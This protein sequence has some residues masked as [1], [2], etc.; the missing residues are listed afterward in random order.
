MKIG[1]DVRCFA[2]KRH[3][4]VEEYTRNLLVKLVESSPEHSFVLFFNAFS[5]DI[6]NFSWITKYPNV[7][8]CRKRIPNK[9]L[10]VCLW[11][12]RRPYLDALIGGVDVFFAP[13]LG[14]L[15]VSPKCRFVVTVHDLSY[16]VYSQTFS[17]KRRLWHL[18]ISPRKLLSRADAIVAVSS[19]T[20]EDI[21]RFYG[22]NEKKI[23]VIYSGISERYGVMSRNDVKLL[24]YKDKWK[25]PY[26]FILSMG[27][28]EP[29]KNITA[30]VRG[31]S[32][33]RKSQSHTGKNNHAQLILAG[34][35]GWR[36]EEIQKEI[37]ES[38]YRKDIR[39]MGYIPEKDKK[40]LY[41]LAT[42]FLYPSLYEGFGFPVLEAMKCG[43]PVITSFSSSLGEIAKQGALYIDPLRPEEIALAL[44]QLLEDRVLYEEMVLKSG[45]V[46]SKY[47]WK[48][49]AREVKS[50]LTEK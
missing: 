8:M 6:P 14:F 17:L 33:Y 24:A 31:Y 41:N 47:S 28:F 19:S 30:L 43:L 40:K 20:K 4:G 44:E 45:K 38:P 12:F 10:N 15:S 5:R 48:Q 50:L 22:I 11:Y 1:V 25:L 23:S 2:G 3:T 37:E 46:C 29:R 36:E 35:S 27:T 34:S 26:R 32:A 18:F 13:N 16:E 39:R 49:C 7:I 21:I 9:I 42:V